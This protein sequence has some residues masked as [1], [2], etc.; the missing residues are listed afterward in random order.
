MKQSVGERTQQNDPTH[1]NNAQWL[2]TTRP[3][4]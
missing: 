3:K 1:Y 2:T 4:R